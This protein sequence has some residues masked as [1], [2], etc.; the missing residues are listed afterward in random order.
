MHAITSIKIDVLTPGEER[1]VDALR[2]V[3]PAIDRIAISEL[4]GSASAKVLLRGAEGPVPLGTLGEG[5]SRMLTLALYLAVTQGGFLLLDEIENGLHWSVMPRLW[6]FLV[7][8]ARALDV[9]VFATTHSKDCL[10]GLADLYRARPDLARD[11]S[12]HRLEVGR[13]TSL[14][15]DASRIAEFIEM[16]LEAR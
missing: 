11:V 10:E 3:E 7:E 9:Q 12:V 13:E 14:L 5:A 1:T 4:A 6:H 15:F 8:T 16:D 2:I